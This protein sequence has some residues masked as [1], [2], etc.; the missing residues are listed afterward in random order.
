MKVGQREKIRRDEVKILI[1]ED[2]MIVYIS[3]TK[4]PPENYLT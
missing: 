1:F 2:D 4:I 3:T